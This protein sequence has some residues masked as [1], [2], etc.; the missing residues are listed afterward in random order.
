MAF[1]EKHSIWAVQFDKATDVILGGITRSRLDLGAEL[2]SEPTS[3]EPYARH[4]AVVARK[5]MASFTT[6]SLDTALTE[7]G[8]LGL[9]VLSTGTVVAINLYAQAHSAGGTRASGSAHRKYNIVRAFLVPRRLRCDFGGDASLD[10]DLIV[11]SDGSANNAVIES[12]AVALPAG[13]ADADRFTIGPVTLGALSF[14]QIKGFELDFGLNVVPEGADSDIYP[15]Y[16]SIQDIK[17]MLTIRGLDAKWLKSD[18]IPFV[19]MAATHANSTIFLRKR[20]QTGA[21]FVVDGTAEHI[22]L[23]M[24]GFLRVTQAF[25]GSGGA[26]VETVAVLEGK[27]DGTNNPVVVTVDSAIA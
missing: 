16:V 14:T 8:A 18:K 10:V 23:T 13:I 3:G 22:K 24:A 1:T 20:A 21:S 15:V 25:D 9:Y 5:P 4:Q 6:L 12:D 26:G 2:R 19:G 11:M 17:P 27:F 7:I